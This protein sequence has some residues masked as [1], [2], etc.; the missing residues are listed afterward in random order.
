MQLNSVIITP[1]SLSLPLC[2]NVRRD[3]TRPPEFIEDTYAEKYDNTTIFYD[4][5]KSNGKIF[6]ISPPLLN[7]ESILENCIV[8]KN[9]NERE[10]ISINTRRLERNQLSW[11]DTDIDEIKEIIFDLA[12]IDSGLD[13]KSRFL[14]IVPSEDFSQELK[15]SKILMTLQLNN[16]LN[17]IK[18]WARYYN[19][20]HG[21]DSVILY[22]NQSTLYTAADIQACLEAIDGLKNVIVV[23][24]D[25]KYGPQGKPWTGPD[26]PW[27]S[28]FCQIGALQD[29]RFK[30]ALNAI[31]LINADIDEFFF[32]LEGENIF[33]ALEQSEKGVIG[34]V[35]NVIVGSPSNTYKKFDDNNISFTDFWK[36]KMPSAVGGRKW[37]GSPKKWNID[38]HPT[39]HW[40][41]N[42]AYQPDSRFS[43]GH[44]RC[45]NNGWKIKERT[46]L[47]NESAEIRPDFALLAALSSAF[48]EQIP[49]SILHQALCDAEV[50]LERLY[51]DNHQER[52][53]QNSLL[54]CITVLTEEKIV[55]NKRWIW[56]N[57]VLVFETNT[58]YG[59]IAFDVYNL[60]DKIRICISVRKKS[61]FPAFAKAMTRRKNILSIFKKKPT[62]QLLSN[63]QGFNIG[64]IRKSG[65]SPE[66]LSRLVSKRII[67]AFENIN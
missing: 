25:F 9:N 6:F 63:N 33:E 28:D 60:T 43:L 59:M 35:G 51:S 52:L 30:F 62:M 48:P 38:A 21:V 8:V 41:R 45:I 39:A 4:V 18:E 66:N 3:N 37:A 10:T 40:V 20:V 2:S 12:V 17:W 13:D 56:R 54:S 29:V 19:I 53:F 58:K 44:F 36:K 49:A 24:W 46:Q 7:L 31:G 61:M 67:D 64:E 16:D 23:K 32:S 50:R 1:N 55:W 57:H 5:F 42:I 15:D 27:D 34:V 22:D 11:I 26:T 65:K 47:Y 14:S